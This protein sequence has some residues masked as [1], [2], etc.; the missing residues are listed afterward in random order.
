MTVAVSNAV[1]A[2][3]QSNVDTKAIEVEVEVVS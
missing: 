2:V 1:T 3:E